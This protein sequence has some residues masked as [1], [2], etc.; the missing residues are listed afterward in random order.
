M[1][2]EN[3]TGQQDPHAQREAEKYDNPIPS[4]E[5][6][7]EAL[8]EAQKPLRIYQ[9]AKVLEVSEEDEERYEALSRRLK[10]MVRDGQLIRNRRGAFGLLKKMDLIKGR[11]L[12]HPDGY[13][14]LVP[15]EGGK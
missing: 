8:E 6:I 10:A 2:T 13:G 15:E 7:L 5:F 4:R 1:T 12:G 11:V 9:V 3:T 14:F